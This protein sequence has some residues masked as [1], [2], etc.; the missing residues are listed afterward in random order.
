MRASEIETLSAN[1]EAAEGAFSGRI[2]ARIDSI[3]EKTGYAEKKE[4]MI[5]LSEQIEGAN[6]ALTE[7]S[8]NIET[9]TDALAK[10][11]ELGVLKDD[12]RMIESQLAELKQEKSLTEKSIANAEKAKVKLSK[13]IAKIDA[14]TQ[15]WQSLK[16]SMG[17]SKKGEPAEVIEMIDDAAGNGE[18]SE[19][20]SEN[21]DNVESTAVAEGNAIYADAGE[22]R[23]EAADDDQ[24]ETFQE[25]E[26]DPGVESR[27]EGM[28]KFT[29]YFRDLHK[30]SNMLTPTATDLLEKLKEAEPLIEEFAEILSDEGE[31]VALTIK[32]MIKTYSQAGNIEPLK[33]QL[34]SDILNKIIR[35]LPESIAL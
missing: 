5:T 12:I 14:R 7:V 24:A 2:D 6:A 17:L 32:D 10:A 35:K 34:K 16:D 30:L 9:Y 33:G 29:A 11:K 28:E 1:I 18:L 19:N 22:L 3:H 20:D 21:I 31:V 15:K 8:Q 13:Q 4:S 25:V 26:T 23:A 27:E